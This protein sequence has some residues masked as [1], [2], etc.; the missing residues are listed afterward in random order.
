MAFKDILARFKKAL[1]K[2]AKLF[3]IRSWFGKKVDQSFLD[4]LEE[5]LIKSDVGVKATDR[6]IA[7]VREAFADKTAG[8]DLLKFVKV[9]VRVMWSTGWHKFVRARFYMRWT[10]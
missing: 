6:V 8:E 2:T 7:R 4:Q 9:K 3:H 5:S 1:A 10:A